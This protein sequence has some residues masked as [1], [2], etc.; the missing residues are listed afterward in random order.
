MANKGQL[1]Q[2]APVIN[3]VMPNDMFGILRPA[4]APTPD[5]QPPIPV[6]HQSLMPSSQSL[7]P[8]HL[9]PGIKQDIATFCQAHGLSEQVLEKFRAHAYTGTQAFR[10]IDVQELKELGFKPGEIVDLK[11]AILEWAIGV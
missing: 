10:Y 11:E 1:T 4:F 5:P 2:A 3:V 8:P 9:Q 6:L 7:I